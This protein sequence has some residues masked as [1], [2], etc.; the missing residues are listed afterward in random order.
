[1]RGTSVRATWEPDFAVRQVCPGLSLAAPPLSGMGGMSV[2]QFLFFDTLGSLVWTGGFIGTGYFFGSNIDTG[3]ATISPRLCVCLSVALVLGFAAI[4]SARSLWR[5][6]RAQPL[7]PAIIESVQLYKEDPAELLWLAGL[8]TDDPTPDLNAAFETPDPDNAGHPF[9]AQWMVTWS[10]KLV[11]AEALGKMTTELRGSARRTALAQR[12]AGCKSAA[13]PEWSRRRPVH[14]VQVERALAAI[15]VFPRCALLLRVF[16]NLSLEDAAVLLGASKELVTNAQ[17]IGLTEL[18][19]NL[20]H[21]QGWVAELS[22]LPRL[23]LAEM[24]PV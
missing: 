9:F 21:E 20:E 17:A 19:R 11:I 16:E 7:A 2:A 22:A 12:V 4:G 23:R 3:S 1:M 13:P 5:K 18:A 15:D 8:I 14:K 6:H 24:Q 10:R